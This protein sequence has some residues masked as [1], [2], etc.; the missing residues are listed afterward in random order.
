[1]ALQDHFA[2]HMPLLVTEFG[3]P[4]SLGS[5]HD[6]TNGRDQGDHT[7]QDAMAM[8]ADMMRMMRGQGHRRGLRL[9]LDRR[10]VQADLEH[11][12]S[13]RTPSAA[14]SGTTP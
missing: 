14:S 8:D 12:W 7:E 9:R 6:G 2:E 5:A 13:T 4:S 3:V 11:R 1:M 10:V